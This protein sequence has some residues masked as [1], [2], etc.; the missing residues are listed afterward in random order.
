[1]S[2][3]PMKLLLTGALALT[4][5]VPTP[6]AHS[7]GCILI[8]QYGPEFDP[9]NKPYTEKGK[10]SLS[11]SYRGSTADK[12]YRGTE[13]QAQRQELGTYVVNQQRLFDLAVTYGV[14]DKLGLSLSLPFVNSSWAIPSPTAP[15]P[16]PRYP[17]RGKG[18][19]DLTLSGRYWIFDTR[20]REH[21]VAVS[22]GVKTPTGNA[23]A[24]DVFPDISG[25]NAAR[26]AVDYSVQPG[27]SGWGLI[28]GAQAFQALGRVTV[29]ANGTYLANPKDMSVTPS[30][31]VGLGF[32]SSPANSDRLYNTVPDQYL[33]RAGATV[34]LPLK[35][36][37]VSVAGRLEGQ[38]RYDLI[39][40]S[41]G[42]RRPGKSGYV[43]PGIAYAFHG[44]SVNLNV[45]ITVYRNREP[46]PYTDAP[47][48]ATFPDYLV[49]LGFGYRFN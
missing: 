23:Y 32:G 44:M 9:F 34:P 25:E 43:E 24:T 17:E 14:S 49:L 19:G 15:T 18:I 38:P 28:M 8:R 48:D 4:L 47:G 20:S 3:H 30:L 35:G 40:A 7:Q 33:V 37:S 31:I 2:T 5:L 12:H 39:G 26:K 36:L 11:F 45:P 10:F 1:M 6:P 29:F 22:L 27:D 46:N 41:H 13:Y 42:F 21:N 16:G